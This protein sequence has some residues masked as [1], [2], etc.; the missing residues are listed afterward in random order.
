V[1]QVCQSQ[2]QRRHTLLCQH[3]YQTTA[4]YLGVP[5][6]PLK[7]IRV[8]SCI[9]CACACS[10]SSSSSSSSVLPTPAYQLRFAS[11]LPAIVAGH[12]VITPLQAFP[13]MYASDRRLSLVCAI[14][15][16]AGLPVRATAGAALLLLPFQHLFLNL[17]MSPCISTDKHKQYGLFC[18]KRSTTTACLATLCSSSTAAVP[19][20]ARAPSV[21]AASA[22]SM[23]SSVS[24]SMFIDSIAANRQM[25]LRSIRRRE[26]TAWSCSSYCRCM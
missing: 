14:L 16:Q 2:K 19:P 5:G 7:W 23:S 10:S 15:R 26:F 24:W 9:L 13:L 18:S 3:A 1:A 20:C 12:F 4:A 17:P 8:S 21:A 6:H 22:A 25:E 11:L